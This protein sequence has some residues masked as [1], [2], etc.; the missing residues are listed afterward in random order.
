M[1]GSRFTE[2]QIIAALKGHAAGRRRSASGG[3]EAAPLEY[4]GSQSRGDRIASG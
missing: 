1:R 4:R 3:Q 2:E